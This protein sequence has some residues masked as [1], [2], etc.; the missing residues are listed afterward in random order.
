MASWRRCANFLISTFLFLLT[1][2]SVR[3]HLITNLFAPDELAGAALYTD[4]AVFL[5]AAGH[6]IRVST[7]FSYYPQWELNQADQG[8]PFRD[9]FFANI[10]VR[11][12]GMYIPKVPTGRTRMLSDL[13]FFYGLLRHARFKNWVPDVIVT[14]SPMFSQCLA[15]RFLYPGK[16]IPRMIIVQ[17]FVVDA[18]LELGILKL[19]LMAPLLRSLERWSFRS[20]QT[21]STIGEPMLDKLKAKI[22]DDRRLLYIPNWIHQSLQQTIDRQMGRHGRRPNLLFYSGNV[23]VKQ[24]LPD[25]IKTFKAT[26]TSWQLQINGGGA[27]IQRL[28]QEIH[29]AENVVIGGVLEE[30]DYVAALLRASACLIT[31][32]PGVGAN[33]LP[34][35]LLPALASGTPVL[36]VCENNTPL[37]REVNAGAFGVVILPDDSAALKSVLE[38]W[39]IDP[40]E[41]NRMGEA[42]RRYGLNFSRQTILS[43]YEAELLRLAQ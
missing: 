40:S 11:R 7:T 17:D 13:S 5:K 14:A 22:G 28:R 30:T 19:P 43:Q 20:A 21:L 9:E 32:K 3:I 35:K 4:F 39:S 16:R 24:G 36:A 41:L 31:Q 6:D 29:G 12:I 33:F 10:P 23:G 25:F 15:Q 27:D 37:A 38:R 34:S 2:K 1:Q 8:V 26:G 42:A 18:A